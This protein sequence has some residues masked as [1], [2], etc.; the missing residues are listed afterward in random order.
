M[1][2]A[3]ILP[4][5]SFLAALA[6]ALLLSA[7]LKAQTQ[8][9]ETD[10]PTLKDFG[11]SLKRLRWDPEKQAAVEIKSD[12]QKRANATDE[13][14]IRV[15]TRLVTCEVLVTD[16]KGRPV[17]GLTDKDFLVTED[18]QPQKISHFSIGDQV[19][20][21]RSIVLIID[22][23][24]SQAPYAKTS[25]DAA[26]SLVDKL[27]PKDRL[28]VVTDDIKL[29]IDFTA[30]KAELKIGLE[31]LKQRIDAD[32][33]G[34]S[35]QFSALM[36]TLREMFGPEDVRPIV[37]FQTDGDETQL[38]QPPTRAVLNTPA[39][40]R[41]IRSF[42]LKDINSAAERSRATIYSI[43]SGIRILGLPEDEQMKRAEI[44]RQGMI[45]S[46]YQLE[47]KPAP[48]TPKAPPGV[49]AHN[50]SGMVFMQ[51]AVAEV[52]ESSGGWTSYLEEPNQANQIY[53]RILDDV[54]RR[55]VIGYYPEQKHQDGKRHKIGIEVRGHP[56]YVVAGRK[57]YLAP[58]PEP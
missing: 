9:S 18:E 51:S 57:T 12:N 36:A 22:Y 21:G 53:A 50:V 15:E 10:K 5:K 41:K 30:N 4:L 19:D 29:L 55:Y 43:V 3:R 26:E 20:V 8:T 35:A 38:L 44:H 31:A 54:N 37:I 48:P 58:E 13:D 46:G 45:A 47:G 39:L 40:A 6:I 1:P 14:V 25:I 23:S 17:A 49:L 33:T 27:G 32:R 7:S 52:A 56:E 34:G 16:Q 42:G 28:A 2:Y 24:F 11:S